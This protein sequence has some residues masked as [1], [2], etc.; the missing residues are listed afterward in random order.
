MTP[1]L[2][3]RP[4]AAPDPLAQP[5]ARANTR[6]DIEQV[7]QQ[8]EALILTELLKAARPKG[9]W[10]GSE[11]RTA[12]SIVEFGEEQLANALAAQG[13]L[14]LTKLVIEGIEQVEAANAARQ[15]AAKPPKP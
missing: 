1:M 7:A 5:D 3:V 12:S 14:G 2:P 4:A 9:G 13:G 10:M 11:D 6:K 8:F 15:T